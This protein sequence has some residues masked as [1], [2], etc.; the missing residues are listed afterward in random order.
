MKKN[1]IFSFLLAGVLIISI[2]LQLTEIQKTIVPI[3]LKMYKVR[4]DRDSIIISKTLKD[5]GAPDEQI[6]SLTE[7]IR[8]VAYT[9][10]VKEELIIALIKTES[11]FNLKARSSKNYQGL[12]QTPSATFVYADVDI[13]HGTRILQDKLKFAN[14]NLFLA[15]CYYKGGDNPQ[16]RAYALETLNLYNKLLEKNRELIK[17]EN[18]RT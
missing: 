13:L 1:N 15:L 7:S 5:L 8:F 6:E 14:G 10:D 9:T 4:L 12:M 2:S 17:E 18:N 11:N 3:R 16:A